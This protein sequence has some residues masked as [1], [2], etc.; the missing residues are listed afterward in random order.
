MFQK[1][2]FTVDVNRDLTKLMDIACESKGPIC[3]IILGGG[4]VKYHVM[5]ACKVA[6][7][8]DYG[9]FVTVGEDWDGSYTGADTNEEVSRRAIK[10][11]AKTVTL[12]SDFSFVFPLMVASTFVKHVYANEKKETEE[13][14]ESGEKSAP[15]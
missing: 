7:G 5:N 9:V 14:Q 4:M 15:Q 6:G 10:P 13:A 11:T 1:P 2:N 3:A 8:L 12:K